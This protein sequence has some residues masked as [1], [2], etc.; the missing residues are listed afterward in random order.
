M[1]QDTGILKQLPLCKYGKN[2]NDKNPAHIA[3]LIHENPTCRH[4][5]TCRNADETH[6][7]KFE[8]TKP[9]VKSSVSKR[10]KNRVKTVQRTRVFENGQEICA[11]YLR[12][13]C[14]ASE[15]KYSHDYSGPC[16]FDPKC[17]NS[18]CEFPHPNR[19]DA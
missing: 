5:P 3:G 8:H 2:C 7:L 16:I 17:G 11:H 19:D 12:G 6:R 15:C 9:P 14:T 18:K 10:D 1:Q 4:D 13:K